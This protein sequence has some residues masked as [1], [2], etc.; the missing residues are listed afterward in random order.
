MDYR[1]SQT[2]DGER[3]PFDLHEQRCACTTL[4]LLLAKPHKVIPRQS[5]SDGV[6]T[7]AA[8]SCREDIGML[9]CPLYSYVETN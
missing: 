7:P 6:K 4:T 5:V 9:P 3:S 2:L 8:Q 1:R